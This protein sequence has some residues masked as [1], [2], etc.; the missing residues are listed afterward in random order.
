MV[1]GEG[2]GWYR[3]CPEHALAAKGISLGRKGNEKTTYKRKKSEGDI[4]VNVRTSF[5][6]P[7]LEKTLQKPI[8][9]VVVSE[10]E[11]PIQ[12][13]AV[14][15]ALPDVSPEPKG[16][17]AFGIAIESPETAF[18]DFFGGLG[19][20]FAVGTEKKGEQL[21]G[22]LLGMG[23]EAE[24]AGEGVVTKVEKTGETAGEMIFPTDETAQKAIA[25]EAGVQG[26]RSETLNIAEESF[27]A[28]ALDE[29]FED[30]AKTK[31]EI[32]YLETPE[33]ELEA[34][35]LAQAERQKAGI[36]PTFRAGEFVGER[37]GEGLG[38]LGHKIVAGVSWARERFKKE[39]G[40]EPTPA[41]EE[42]MVEEVTAQVAETEEM[43]LPPQ[44]TE[45]VP[46]PAPAQPVVTP[47]PTPEPV[48]E[49]SEAEAQEIVAELERQR[50]LKENNGNL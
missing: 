28:K 14:Q 17:H 25:G 13:E 18:T 27:G 9:D 30:M 21:G 50:L 42:R 29:K 34:E 39:K 41:E 36:A 3:E 31:I 6:V 24:E 16:I 4:I 43:A 33:D 23:A 1:R 38:Y 11:V 26:K 48:R 47:P 12:P 35:S 40:R 7:S 15:G 10:Q 22:G 49:I 46:V 19:E 45:P 37:V 32:N 8:T 20:A 44:A 2:K 5:E